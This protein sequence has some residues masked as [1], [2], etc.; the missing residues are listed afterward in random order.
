MKPW[1][2]RRLTCAPG[3]CS[4]LAPPGSAVKRSSC[5]HADSHQQHTAGSQRGA[6]HRWS[7]TGGSRR[8]T[9]ACAHRSERQ[10][11][12]RMGKG[13]PWPANRQRVDM[14]KKRSRPPQGGA[15]V[16]LHSCLRADLLPPLEPG[17]AAENTNRGQRFYFGL[18]VQLGLRDSACKEALVTWPAPPS[19]PHRYQRQLRRR[20]IGRRSRTPQARWCWLQAQITSCIECQAVHSEQQATPLPGCLT[21]GGNLHAASKFQTF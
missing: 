1:R 11:H 8:G 16:Q 4:A 15:L 21:E 20:Q 3:S 17:G 12:T 13:A 2:S 6:S 5:A 10:H 7:W 18:G 14:M 19:R 9:C